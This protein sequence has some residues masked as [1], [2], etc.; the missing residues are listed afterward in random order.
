MTVSRSFVVL[1]LLAACGAP[2]GD[3]APATTTPTAAP[4]AQA[5]ATMPPNARTI[6]PEQRSVMVAV[7]K[8]EAAPEKKAWF[9]VG[10][11][12]PETAALKGQLESAF[13]EAGWE[14]QTQTVTGMILKPGIM[15]LIAE[16]NGPSYADTA[17]KALD[18]SGLEVKV[19]SGYRPYF[20]EK[21]KE[22]ANWVGIPMAADQ[23]YTVVIGPLPP[24]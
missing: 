16:E 11:G 21:K 24:S 1:A 8:A 13:K 15:M 7:L 10:P 3:K 22:N 14:T 4:A 17:Q 9:T 18:A 6:S 12:N 23:A 2:E 20:E 5:P 19:A